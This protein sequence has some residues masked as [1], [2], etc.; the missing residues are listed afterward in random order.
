MRQLLHTLLGLAASALACAALVPPLAVADRVYHSEHLRLAAV[1]D[2][3]LRSGFVQNIKAE[4][5]RIYAHEIFV[6][7]GARKR[8]V[9]TVTRDFFFQD[10]ECAGSLV[11][12]DV[13]IAELRTNASGN[14]RA[15]VFVEPA[16]V[17]GFEGVHGVMWT[18]RDAGGAIAYRT[19]CTAVTLD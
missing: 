15:D 17:A 4:G 18:V 7:N 3:P 8:T 16:E 9:Y 1:G 12:H 6:L 5:P 14:A 19:P 11:F 2:A 10:P 13:D